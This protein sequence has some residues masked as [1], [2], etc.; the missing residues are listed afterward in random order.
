MIDDRILDQVIPIP[1]I[2]EKKEEIFQELEANGFVITNKRIGGVYIT[3][4][5]IT[6]KCYIELKSLA[7][8]I[9]KNIFLDS[10]EGVWV[11]LIASDFSK[12]R[13]LESK[14]EGHVKV[15]RQESGEAISITKGTVFKT[16]QDAN[17]DELKY[18]ATELT[19]LSPSATS[20]DIPVIAE[21]AGASY[22]VAQN[23]IIKCLVNLEGIDG[24]TNIATWITKEGTDIE[25][26]ESLRRRTKL[27][28]SELSTLPIADKYKNICEGVQGVFLADV[29]DQHPRGQGTIDVY[30]TSAAGAASPNLIGLVETAVGTIKGPYDNVLVRSTETVIQDVAVEIDIPLDESVKGVLETAKTAILELLAIESGKSLNRLGHTDII[31]EIRNKIPEARA[32]RV[33][34]PSTDIELSKGKILVA[35]K[36]DITVRQV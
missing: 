18:I 27:S 7:R 25:D 29:D 9:L 5:M 19:I 17:G 6:L 36:I 23:Q 12:M 1:D 15:S 4:V 8:L 34:K 3:L 33:T 11:E 32:V 31:Y 28:W 22:N 24:I 30:I 26:L 2:N 14:T 20:A 13:K 21:Y 35:G 16:A 10:A